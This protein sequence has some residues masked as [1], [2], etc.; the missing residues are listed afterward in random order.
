MNLKEAAKIGSIITQHARQKT[1]ERIFA[2]L[3]D[4]LP[5][6]WEADFTSAGF[7]CAKSGG[8]RNIRQGATVIIKPKP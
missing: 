8:Y 6:F 4:E 7:K 1:V 3:S 5:F 2:T